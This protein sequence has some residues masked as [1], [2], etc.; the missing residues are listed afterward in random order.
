MRQALI[1]ELLASAGIPDAPE[2]VSPMAGAGNNSVWR[3][4]AGGRR[5]VAKDYLK[6]SRAWQGQM[7]AELRFLQFAQERV[8]GLVPRILARDGNRGIA[9]FDMLPG[10][11]AVASDI[12][13]DRVY[14]AGRFIARLNDPSK[15]SHDLDIPIAAEARFSPAGHIRLISGRIRRLER[16]VDI[17]LK[18]EV[19]P[20]CVRMRTLLSHAR[21]LVRQG[22]SAAPRHFSTLERRGRIVSPSD[23]AFHNAL[24]GPDG[25]LRF[26]DFE[27]AGWDD[28]AK[29]VADFFCQVR[30][31]VS[32]SLLPVFLDGL[33]LTN[34]AVGRLKVTLPAL[35]TAYRVKWVCIV[36]N[37]VLHERLSETRRSSDSEA[38]K[39]IALNRLGLA[40][41]LLFEAEQELKHRMQPN[42]DDRFHV[43]SAQEHCEGLSRQGQ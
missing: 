12:T 9:V 25:T 7:A 20:L 13:P 27:Y 41:R 14:E 28:P 6:P 43:G 35:L 24:V 4:A 26:V 29:L 34:Q 39:S 42:G 18:N 3:I 23:F 17:S 16:G 5:Y 19:L 38:V 1:G 22:A 11:A 31:P 21:A 33:A 8:A 40:R 2:R 32:V 30:L 15:R 36:L 37:P 10:R